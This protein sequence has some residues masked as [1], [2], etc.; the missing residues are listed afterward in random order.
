MAFSVD[1]IH[2]DV[3][4]SSRFEVYSCVADGAA[5]S[6]ATGLSHI[7]AVGVTI[8]S[9]TTAAYSARANELTAGTSAGG[10]V[11]VTGIASGDEFYLQVWG[12]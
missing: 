5:D 8:Q 6:I 11:A 2:G 3:H 1:K 7:Y 9:M 10:Y 12:R 4:G